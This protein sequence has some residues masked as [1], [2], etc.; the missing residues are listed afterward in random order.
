MR[1]IQHEIQLQQDAPL[2]NIGMYTLYVLENEEIKKKVQEFLEKG[3]IR[4]STF[5]G[6][7][8]IVLVP[9]KYGTWRMCMDFWALNKIIVNNCYH[10][11][12]IDDLLDQLKNEI[13]LTNL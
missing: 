1:E 6:G 2:P 10:F 8:P 11:P 7:S 3:V 4:P 12:R 9:N 13:Y 5:P